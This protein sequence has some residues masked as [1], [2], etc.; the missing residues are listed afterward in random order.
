MFADNPDDCIIKSG[1]ILVQAHDELL[2]GKIELRDGNVF[3]IENGNVTQAERWL[4]KR[5]GKLPLLAHRILSYIPEEVNY[6]SPSGRILDDIKYDPLESEKQCRTVDDSIYEFLSRPLAGE[7][8]VLYLTSDAG[9]GKTT[10]INQLARKQAE[11][12]TKNETEWLLLPVQLGGK[13][14]MR[15]DDVIIGG[16]VNRLRFPYLYYDSIMELA[17]LGYIVFA[18]DGFE[19][20]FI[21]TPTGEAISALGN[22]LQKL[23]SSGRIVVAAR[24]AYFEFKSMKTQSQLFDSFPSCDVSF[25]KISIDRW[26]KEQFCD[27]GLRRGVTDCDHLY[28]DIRAKLGQDNHPLISRAVLVKRLFTI[29]ESDNEEND[30]IRNLG[31]SNEDYFKE[32]IDVIID[33]EV[34]EK[35]IDRT[36]DL[37]KPLL[38][39]SE[40][41][42]LLSN[43]AEEMWI[44]STDSL[45]SSVFDMVTEL[46]CESL[47]KPPVLARQIVE[48]AKQHSLIIK[49]TTNRD[50]FQFDHEEFRLY[51]LGLKIVEY[52]ANQSVHDLR[53]ILRQTTLSDLILELSAKGIKR[54]NVVIEQCIKY[55]QNVS[56]AEAPISYVREN[57]STLIMYMLDNYTGSNLHVANQMFHGDILRSKTLSNIT[58]S[59]CVFQNTNTFNTTITCC[60]FKECNFA[61]FE[62]EHNSEFFNVEFDET[63]PTSITITESEQQIFDPKCIVDT[64]EQHGITVKN[65]K[66]EDVN[67]CHQDSDDMILLKRAS[68]IF[69]R[70]TFIN[71]DTFK[72]KLGTEANHF[73]EQIVPELIKRNIIEETQYRGGGKQKR[74][75]V[76]I[77]MSEFENACMGSGGELDQFLSYFE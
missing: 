30:V 77:R 72:L 3:V 75:R 35:W 45:S 71:E 50:E 33:R 68:R 29:I 5:V 53:R 9:E 73:M 32:F 31:L 14:F 64:L 38:S 40:H 7:T 23:D 44:S 65:V 2:E 22:L 52:T 66:H 62:I 19:E 61:G 13:P 46:Y 21:E 55:L 27:Y 8:S 63:I 36:G 34:G 58:F 47:N 6:V 59:N 51:F 54:H 18:L 1:T 28:E 56:H 41:Y 69:Y 20:M 76:K 10:I 16:L 49:S 15:L 39:K 42:A 12:Y 48:R 74:Y 25:S 57:V 11:R 67:T 26:R 60:L 4:A 24:K 37:A 70:S 17:K 43:I